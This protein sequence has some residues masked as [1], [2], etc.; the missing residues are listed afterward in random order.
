[1][2]GDAGYLLDTNVLSELR[3]KSPDP[4]VV[5]FVRDCDE[6][7]TY[8]SVLTMGE[9]R[10]GALQKQRKDPAAARMLLK[11]IDEL[12]AGFSERI[13]SVDAKTAVLW[14]EF[15]ADR[16]RSVI[17]T[18][19]AATAARHGLTL[20]TRNTKDVSGLKVQVLN[21]WKR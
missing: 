4:G 19:L 9:L 5:D 20:V 3:K 17:D 7:K 14:G 21:P 11:W 15:S 1:M 13:L 16:S 12:Q 10:K 6:E 8:I 18:L 2:S